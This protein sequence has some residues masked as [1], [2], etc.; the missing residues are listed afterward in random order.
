MPSRP[1]ERTLK[2]LFAQSRNHC[3]A[4]GCEQPVV[5]QATSF[6]DA[7]PVAQIAHIVAR[8]DKGPRGDPKFSSAQLHD[9]SN[10][11][12]LCGHHHALVDAQDSTFTVDELRRWKRGVVEAHD[13]RAVFL[14]YLRSLIDRLGSARWATDP[15]LGGPVLRL[16]QHDL[17]LPAKDVNRNRLVTAADASRFS[18]LVV[19]GGPGAGKTWFAA[20]AAIACAQQAVEALDAGADPRVV[21]IPLFTTVAAVRD[22]PQRPIRER[23]V[24]ASLA[25]LS[26]HARIAAALASAISAHEHVLVLLDSAD[27]A[28]GSDELLTQLDAGPWSVVLTTR[29][30][31]WRRQ[32]DVG[33][34]DN[35]KAVVA[36][37]PLSY[38]GDVRRFVHAWFGSE[39]TVAGEALLDRIARSHRLQEAARHALAPCV[40]LH[41]RT[42]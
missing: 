25:P 12:L 33:S 35:D 3:A 21:R 13:E 18:R 20:R 5:A 31:A 2:I 39:A 24:A 16:G 9:E 15:R 34:T 7:A 10:L 6:D 42:E 4:P 28:P 26:A 11:I 14:T 1:S 22:Q 32:F 29:P 23:V 30:A 36:L 38:P 41:P 27:E 17:E 19:L 40:L 37:E 8:S